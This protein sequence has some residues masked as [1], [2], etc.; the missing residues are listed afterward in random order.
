ME[1]VPQ[2]DKFQFFEYTVRKGFLNLWHQKFRVY[3]P[4]GELILYSELKALKLKEDVSVYADE[5]KNR[6][7]FRIKARQMLDISATYDIV[8]SD[9]QTSLGAV[10]RAGIKSML[11]DEWTIMDSSDNEI[12]KIQEDSMALALVRRFLSNLIPQKFTVSING[13]PLIYF[14]QNFNPFLLKMHLDF[15]RDLNQTL[16]RRVGIIAAIMLCAIEGR[17]E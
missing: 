15:N 2:S 11:R 3:D 17:Q 12:A 1:T 9:S 6:E 5:S 10:R 7:M 14:K 16:D 13:E 8:D 4:H